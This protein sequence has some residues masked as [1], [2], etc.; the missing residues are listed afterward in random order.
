MAGWLAL[1]FFFPVTGCNADLMNLN[2]VSILPGENNV[3]V[4]ATICSDINLTVSS[5]GNEYQVFLLCDSTGNI[6]VWK[7]AWV[8][9][10]NLSKGDLILL[11]GKITRRYSQPEIY[12][13]NSVVKQ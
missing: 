11:C 5:G 7:G 6:T 4:N 8:L 3:L 13:V 12:Y 10:N 1:L 2:L 9:E